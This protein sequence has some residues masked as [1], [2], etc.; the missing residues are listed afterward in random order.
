MLELKAARSLNKAHEAQL[1]HYLRATEVEVGLL[2][3]F[4]VR[5]RFRPLLFDSERKK[6]RENPRESVANHCG[7]GVC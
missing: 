2:L 4:G 5:P 1:L 3:N 6:I 7:S